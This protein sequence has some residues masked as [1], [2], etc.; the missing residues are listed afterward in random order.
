MSVPVILR[1]I[2]E[3]D[4][5][6]I[7]SELETIRTG[8][9]SQFSTRLQVLLERI[10]AMPQMYGILWKTVRAAIIHRFRYVVYYIAF[11]D[12]TEVLA[13]MHAARDASAWQ[14]RV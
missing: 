2:A 12:R 10:E 9:G 8:L 14:S 11:A 7:H 3:A 1:P 6:S 5:R 13:V 4:V